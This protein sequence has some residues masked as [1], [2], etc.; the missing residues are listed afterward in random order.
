MLVLVQAWYQVQDLKK[1]GLG[2]RNLFWPSGKV[3]ESSN[4]MPEKV[5]K[6]EIFLSSLVFYQ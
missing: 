2:G 4:L 5:I 6:C 3:T 1:R